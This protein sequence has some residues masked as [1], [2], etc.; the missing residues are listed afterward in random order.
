MY[1]LCFSEEYHC[2][3]GPLSAMT[4]DFA[5]VVSS[6]PPKITVVY[7]SRIVLGQIDDQMLVACWTCTPRAIVLAASSLIEESLYQ[8]IWMIFGSFFLARLL[9]LN[10]G[11]PHL[12]FHG[13]HFEFV[14][15]D[16]EEW[17]WLLLPFALVISLLPL[18]SIFQVLFDWLVVC[19]L[20]PWVFVL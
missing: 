5:S 13:L 16:G 10:L 14:R 7:S 11:H 3:V 20:T 8:L 18:L 1:G 9:L 12:W 2:W 6:S 19:P 17:L 4:S 15:S